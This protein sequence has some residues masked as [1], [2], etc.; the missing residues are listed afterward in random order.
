MVLQKIAREI[1]RPFRR[2]PVVAR[3]QQPVVMEQAAPSQPAAPAA[4]AF[5]A[6]LVRKTDNFGRITWLGQPIWQNVLDLWTIQETIAEIR[7]ELLIECGTNR[8]GSS[9]FFAHL[10]DLL[11]Q[12]L[13]I[14]I[15]VEKMHKL[16]HPR[17][18]YLLG[19]STAPE[20]VAEVQA[21]ASG[22]RGPVLVILDSDHSE[23]HVAA[24]LAVYAPLVTRGSYCLVQD[25]VID[26]LPMMAGARPGPLPAIDQFVAAHP[27][28]EIDHERCERFIVSHHPRGWLRRK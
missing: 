11:G 4:E 13:I 9:L 20:I 25:G 10:M 23:A 8:G 18:T 1:M 12:G 5:F 17:I 7:P 6:D 14:T 2:R 3:R 22:T 26:T 15:D 24:E 27:E 28:F 21:R 16:S 19:S